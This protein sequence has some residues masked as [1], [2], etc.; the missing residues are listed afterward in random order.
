MLDTH[1]TRSLILFLVI[2]NLLLL[3]ALKGGG[4]LLYRNDS[5]GGAQTALCIDPLFRL[6]GGWE[7]RLHRMW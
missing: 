3:L 7:L 4:L 6:R 1:F 2:P 5:P